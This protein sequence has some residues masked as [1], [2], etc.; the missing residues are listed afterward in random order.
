MAYN[1]RMRSDELARLL[2]EVPGIQVSGTEVSGDGDL[3]TVYVPAIGDTVRLRPDDVLDAEP[4]VVPTGAPGVQ[5]GIRRGH[6][7]W[8]LIVTVDDVVFM[9]GDPADI[10]RDDGL[11]WQVPSM[12]HLVAYSEM[13]RD[14]RALGR[15][16]DRP[17]T[18]LDPEILGPTLLLHRCF[19]A[20]AVQVGLWPV[21]VAA[22]WEYSWAR[23]GRDLPLP[24]FR[25]DVA[26]NALMDDVTEARSRTERHSK[27]ATAEPNVR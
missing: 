14:V 24:S 15:A 10:V 19:L 13:H 26:W 18:A 7:E 2:G 6:E 25:P 17:G 23:T 27:E 22:W 4:V 12:P 9:P 21:R 20:G 16:I 5:L 1:G 8:P 3:V 11:P